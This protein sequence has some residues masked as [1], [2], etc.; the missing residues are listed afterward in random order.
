MAIDSEN[1]R[2]SVSNWFCR[3]PPAPDGTIAAV[4]RQHVAGFY[5]GIAAGAPPELVELLLGLSDTSDLLLGLSDT[6]D[7]LL[8]LSD[9]SDL[10]L[11][12]AS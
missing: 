11:G 10:L 3:I 2:R 1:K 6:S 7:L 8:G 9:T 12:V 5:S 4:D